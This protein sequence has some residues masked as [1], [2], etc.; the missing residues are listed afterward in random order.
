MA[1]EEEMMGGGVDNEEPAK[2]LLGAVWKFVR[3]HT[4]RGTLLGTTAIVTRQLQN[5]SS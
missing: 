3:P 5:P 1:M 2:G 4:I